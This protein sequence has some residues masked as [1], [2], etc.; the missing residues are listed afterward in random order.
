M[1]NSLILT[2]DL[3]E[4]FHLCLD[5][6]PASWDQ[7]ENRFEKNTN[8][9]LEILNDHGVKATFLVLGWIAKKYPK[10]IKEISENGHDI[11]SH[12]NLHELIY[13]QSIKE[14][15]ADLKES[16]KILEDIISKKITIYRAPAFSINS[17]SKWA[18][19]IIAENGI[20]YDMSL[21][22]GHHSLG[23]IT[24]E[25]IDE[26]FYI[27]TSYGRILEYPMTLTKILGL[28]FATC[29][30]GYFRLLPFSVMKTLLNHN[31]YR[32]TYFH[33]RDFDYEQPRVSMPTLRYFKTYVGLSS[34]RSKFKK[35]LNNFSP[36][37][38][39]EDLRSREL[40]K[41]RTIELERLGNTN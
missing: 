14:F 24:G 35:L 5:D 22:Q 28:S 1:N 29:G 40:G 21:F 12:S 8:Y 41:L 6:E 25:K 26:P 11:G 7:Y 31:E 23:G 3:E 16:L 9:L 34:S 37:S 4:W 10:L 17:S 39:S 19:D 15:E 13:N 33:P 27:N 18:L 30:G 2:F 38:L 36:I 20:K 32:M